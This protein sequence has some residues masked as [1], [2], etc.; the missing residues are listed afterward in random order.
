MVLFCLTVLNYGFKYI[1]IQYNAVQYDTP[2]DLM[3]DHRVE[4]EFDS[5]F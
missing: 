2:T 5:I 3:K 4:L 1:L